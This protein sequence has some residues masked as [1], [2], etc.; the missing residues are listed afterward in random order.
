[1]ATLNIVYLIEK[2]PITKLNATYNNKLINK[3]KDNFTETQQQL[4]VASFYS[5]LKYD[6]NTDF[7]INL[8]DIWNWLGFNQK[9]KARILLE[10]HFLIDIDYKNL[11]DA[12]I[13]QDKKHGGHNKEVF[14][15]NIKTFKL[16][17]IKAGTTKSVEVHNYFIKLEE[18]LHEI[19]QEETDELKI[20]LIKIKDDTKE[21]IKQIEN[22]TKEEIKMEGKSAKQDFVLD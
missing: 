7:I 5:Y 18:F 14:I 12:S 17:C 21:E 22:K 13:K 1:M 10:K 4:F 9:V 2:N 19:V 11:L 8:D 16:L 3:I 20:Q 15:M 6:K